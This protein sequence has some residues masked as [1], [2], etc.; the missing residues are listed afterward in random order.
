MTEIESACKQGNILNPIVDDFTD[1]FKFSTD[2]FMEP[3]NVQDKNAAN[4]IR[5]FNLNEESLKIRRKDV[6][7]SARDMVKGGM[8]KHEVFDM[9]APYGFVS[10][11][12]FELNSIQE[13][14][15]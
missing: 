4:T 13:Q 1:R 5:V 10:A 14:T 6:M 15:N 3:T 11:L 7:K 12:E 8:T 2:G 9:L